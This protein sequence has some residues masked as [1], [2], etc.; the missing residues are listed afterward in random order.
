MNNAFLPPFSSLL[1]KLIK[2][3]SYA[4]LPRQKE[5]L[6]QSGCARGAESFRLRHVGPQAQEAQH[7][8]GETR[9]IQTSTDTPRALVI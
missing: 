3:D 6:L 1:L 7:E 9:E 2:C 5:P 8:D 4:A